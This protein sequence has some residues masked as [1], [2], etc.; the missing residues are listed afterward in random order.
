MR[1]DVSWETIKLDET[2]LCETE[3]D[4]EKPD[5]EE[6]DGVASIETSFI[7]DNVE[8]V[9]SIDGLVR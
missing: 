7:V 6:Y 4:K 2:F 3:E 5:L 9:S 1:D 8:N